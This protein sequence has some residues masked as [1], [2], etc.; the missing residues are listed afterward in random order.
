MVIMH[1]WFIGPMEHFGEIAGKNNVRPLF[2][3]FGFFCLVGIL[4]V[5]FGFN[6][7]VF[8][9]WEGQHPGPT[10][11]RRHVG[12]EVLNVGG[13]LTHGNLALEARVDFLAVVEH[14]LI[15]ARVGSEWARLTGKCLASSWAPACQGTSHVGNAGVGVISM[16]GAP[17]ALPTFATA[18]F[19]R[20]FDYG[21]AVRCMLPLGFGKF[22]NLVVLY[23]YQGADVDAEQLALTEQLF[24]AALGELSVVARGSLVSWLGISTYNPPKSLAWQKG[25]R[26]GSGLTLMKLG[27]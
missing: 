9:D 10:P 25:F 3:L 14:R 1:V 4:G 11:L 8:L 23:G 21:R 12:V 13:W 24:D 26:L 16:R 17:L 2:L 20:F 15:P 6:P 19:K 7:Y 22:M 5:G 18:Q 27:L